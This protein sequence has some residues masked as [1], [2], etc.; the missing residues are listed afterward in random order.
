MMFGSTNFEVLFENKESTIRFTNNVIT[1]I[2]KVYLN[3]QHV[4]TKWSPFGRT[5]FLTI[6][7]TQTSLS[8]KSH[9]L[10]HV[11]ELFPNTT[12]HQKFEFPRLEGGVFKFFFKN[13]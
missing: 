8:I 5:H 4:S 7:N 11:I 6:N 12:V 10:N 13:I 9:I 1:G 3:E 2:E